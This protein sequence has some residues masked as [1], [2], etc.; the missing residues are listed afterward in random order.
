MDFKLDD[1]KLIRINY[2]SM[3]YPPQIDGTD[4]D[5]LFDGLEYAG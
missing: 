5:D 1:G 3:K 4:I 2:T